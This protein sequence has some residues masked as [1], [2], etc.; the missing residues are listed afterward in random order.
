M[1]KNI[2]KATNYKKVKENLVSWLQNKVKSA[3]LKGA[4]VGLSRY[5]SLGSMISAVLLPVYIALW[6][7]E[8]AIIAAAASVAVL[9]VA[10]HHG[11]IGRLAAGTEHRLG[12]H[13]TA[14][15]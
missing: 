3:G 11:N 13:R 4:V 6:G 10:R 12:E 15:G 7:G 5:V 2:T 8:A 9:V 1:D 14:D